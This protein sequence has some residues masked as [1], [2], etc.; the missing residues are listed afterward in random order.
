V[1]TIPGVREAI[2]LDRYSEAEVEIA[3]V[4]GALEGLASH[5]DGASSEL[6]GAGSPAGR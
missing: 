4:A 6:A 3:R 1:K 2:E 5:L